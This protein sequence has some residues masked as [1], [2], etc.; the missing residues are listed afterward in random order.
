MEACDW[1]RAWNRGFSLVESHLRKYSKGIPLQSKICANT[2]IFGQFFLI[3]GVILT[4]FS[5]LTSGIKLQSSGNQVVVKWKL[6][7]SQVA[8]KW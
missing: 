2:P 3:E 1:S 8:V 7:G 5:I 4:I 6:S